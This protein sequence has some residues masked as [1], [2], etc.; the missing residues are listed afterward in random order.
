M[1][2]FAYLFR[3]VD[4]WN[5]RTVSAGDGASNVLDFVA[6]ERNLLREE[7]PEHDAE[8]VHLSSE[9]PIDASAAV[10]MYASIKGAGGDT[11]AEERG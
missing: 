5:A 7:L 9:H 8:R 4:G 3:R 10:S 6:R 11:V 2:R 1:V